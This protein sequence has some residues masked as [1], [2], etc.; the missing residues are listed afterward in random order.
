MTKKPTYEE[1]EQRVKELENEAFD[2]KQADGALRESEERYRTILESIEE[3]YFEVD[4]AGNFTFFNDSLSKSLGYSNDELAGMN[5]RDY[6]PPESS[7]KIYDLFTQIYNKGT[8]LKKG[9]YEIIR[10][11]G[12][13]GFHELSASLMKNQAGQPIGFRGIAYDITERKQ[14]EEA[15]R[16]SEEKYRTILESIEDGYFEVDLGGNFTF[17]NHSLCKILGYSKDELM[18]MNNRQYTDE[19]NAK[20]LYQTFNKVYTT[21]KPHKSFH[22]PVIRKDS[23]KRVVDASVSLRRDAEGEPIGFSGIVRDVT[24]KQRLQ[25]QLQQAKKMESIGTLAGGIAHNF[26]NLLM[27]IQGNASIILLDIESSNPRHKNLKNI[28]KLVENGAK[29]TAQL[30]GYAREGSYEVNIISL[31]QFDER[32]LEFLSDDN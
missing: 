2:R 28:E 14:I 32:Q 30:L 24:E 29:L 31:N 23:T 5:N 15:L 6:M 10:K 9:S 16:E 1:L 27:G 3:I 18:G 20:K 4:I 7:K 19:K 12:S 26:N 11:D 21:G 13:R 17:F 25:A 22:W 8:P